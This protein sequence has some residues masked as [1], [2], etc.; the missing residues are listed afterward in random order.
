MSSLSESLA[1]ARA[2]WNANPRLRIG[3]ALI[4]VIIAVYLLL[5]LADAREALRRDVAREAE[6]LAKIEA[7]A[8]QDAWIERADEAARLREA[9]E[10]QLPPARTPGLAQAAMQGSLRELLQ[11]YGDAVTLEVAAATELPSNPGIVRVSAT[12][13]ARDFGMDRSLALVQAIEASPQLLA[14]TSASIES[15]TA[16]DLSLT[17]N[18]YFRLEPEAADVP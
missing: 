13:G 3:A 11:P 7:L 2:E 16:T 15:R 18:G 1:G 10:S 4:A 8:G 9:L 12:L 5:V 6:R 17:V 14:I